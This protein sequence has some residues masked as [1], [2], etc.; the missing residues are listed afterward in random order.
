MGRRIDGR[1]VVGRRPLRPPVGRPPPLRR[2]RLCVLV[3]PDAPDAAG[4]HVVPSLG[5]ARP[6]RRAGGDGGRLAFVGRAVAHREVPVA[7]APTRRVLAV[8]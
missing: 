6:S 7:A 5:D 8:R 3:P 1:F 2:P 4:D